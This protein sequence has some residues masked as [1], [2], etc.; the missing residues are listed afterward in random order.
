VRRR[1]RD[2]PPF[3]D[4]ASAEQTP[5]EVVTVADCDGERIIAVRLVAL[6]PGLRAVGEEAAA[7]RPDIIAGNQRGYRLAGHSAGWG[8]EYRCRQS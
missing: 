8:R 3:P 7:D 6:L 2:P 5:G 1:G 4:A